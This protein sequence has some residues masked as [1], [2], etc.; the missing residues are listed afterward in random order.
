MSQLPSI[1]MNAFSNAGSWL[2]GIGEKIINGLIQGIKNMFGK[3]KGALTGL[4][5][6]LPSWKGPA[7]RDKTLLAPAGRLIIGGLI[8][9]LESQYGAVRRSLSRLTGDIAAT[10]MPT[11]GISG[12][13]LARETLSGATINVYALTPNV[14]VGRVVARALSEWQAQ[15]G[16]TR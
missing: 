9:S 2:L 6:L 15:N 13:V 14:E 3:V 10:D 7:E 5:N 4:T 16:V 1:V 11:L 8:T 12:P